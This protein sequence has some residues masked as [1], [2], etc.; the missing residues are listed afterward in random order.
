[1]INVKRRLMKE[2]ADRWWPVQTDADSASNGALPSSIW[3]DDHVQMCAQAEFDK[4]VG[5]KVFQL[6]SH[7]RPGNIA[8][9]ACQVR[10]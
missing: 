8:G 3:T 1:M 9:R 7:N 5:D 2:I 4:V 10:M 6:D